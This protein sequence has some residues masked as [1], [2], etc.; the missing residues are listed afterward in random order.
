MCCLYMKLAVFGI[1]VR[2]SRMSGRGVNQ[3]GMDEKIGSKGSSL[4]LL[5]RLDWSERRS[6]F[7]GQEV[8][9]KMGR[10]G[11][12]TAEARTLAVSESKR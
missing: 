2:S 12:W 4:R 5:C 10:L 7:C 1:L 6:E 8:L 3:G 9:E 11:Y